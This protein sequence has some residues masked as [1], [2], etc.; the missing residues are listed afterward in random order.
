MKKPVFVPASLVIF[1]M[2]AFAVV[3]SGTASDAFGSLNTAITDGVG[4]WYVL[5]ATGFVLFALYCGLSRIG[6][7]R[8]GDDDEKPE[9][10]MLSWFAM[11]F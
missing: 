4:W 1:A 2:I 5:A 8:L 9:F 7:I 6:N 11:L 10:G 3:Y